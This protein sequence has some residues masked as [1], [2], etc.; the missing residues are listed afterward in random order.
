MKLAEGGRQIDAVISL[1]AD[2]DEV[3]RRLLRPGTPLGRSGLLAA[4][5]PH[6]AF[7]TDAT[8][9]S[10]K[11]L[12]KEVDRENLFVKIPAT[13]EAAPAI[14]DALAE[15]LLAA[16]LELFSQLAV[17]IRMQV[18]KSQVLKF[19]AQFTHS[20]TVSNRCEDVHRLFGYALSLFRI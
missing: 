6:L 13:T 18:T 8:L 5:A 7:D 9:A 10:A 17:G 19:A 1:Q 12:W 16:L 3:V 2:T 14:S 20:Q 11:E 15:A 4:K